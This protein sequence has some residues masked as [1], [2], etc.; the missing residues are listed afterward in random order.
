MWHALNE[1]EIFEKLKSSENGLD[2]KEAAGRL[3]EYGLNEL[4]E[5]H[6]ISPIKIFLSQFVSILVYI[7]IIAA[8]IS[9]LLK[10]WIDFWVI[11]AIVLLNAF[12]GFIQQYKA[13]RAVRELKQMI[14]PRVKVIR[15][16]RLRTM[17]SLHIVPGDIIALD[18]GDKIPADAR[19]LVAN[20]LQ[21][22]EAVLTGE[23]MPV[24]KEA[25]T[26]KIG[27]ELVDRNNMLYMGTSIVRG[28]ARAIVVESGMSTE[29]G[30]IAESV[31]TIEHEKTPL[32]KRFDIFAK[33][34]GFFIIAV[35]IFIVLFGIF[36]GFDKLQIFLTSIAL[37][38]SA[39]PEGLPAVLTLGLALA[40]R[41]LLKVNALVKKLPASETLGSASVLCVDKTGTITSEE[42]TVSY[43]YSN[44]K[45]LA[46]N[47][48]V[49]KGNAARDV[50]KIGVLCN[51]SRVEK[52]RGKNVF[53]G[54]PTEK[55]LLAIAERAGISKRAQTIQEPK[56][57]EFPFSSERKMMSIVR[58]NKTGFIS[59]VKGSPEAVLSRSAY[60]LINGEIRILTSKRRMQLHKEYEKFASKALRVLAFAFKPIKREITL[61]NAESKLIFA[62]FQAMIDPPRPEI[63]ESIKKCNEFGIRVMMITG[64]SA[65]TARV[66]A[67][68]IGLK[69]MLITS[70]ELDKLS[71]KKL[72]K[73]IS[74]VSIFARIS[75]E[76]K[77]RIVESLKRNGEIVAVTGDGVN[78]V[79]ALKKADVA[80]AMG[81]RGTDVARDVSDIVLLDDNF[82]SIVSAVEEGRKTYSNIRKFTKFLLSCN[83]SEIGLVI[84]S[85]FAKLPLPLL[86]L[87]ILWINLITDSAPALALSAEPKNSEKIRDNN[88]KSILKGM[89]GFIL[90]GGLLAFLSGIS[91]FFLGLWADEPIEKIRTSVLTT[92]ILFQLLFAFTCRSSKSLIK[93]GP[94]T[95]RWL[96]AAFAGAFALQILLIY[97]P[98][99]FAFEVVPLGFNDWIPIIFASISGLLVFEIMKLI[100]FSRLIFN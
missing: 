92:S 21:A 88:D 46:A 13:E 68:Q 57:K 49:K 98:L 7:L 14:V 4:K 40:T 56:V 39:I 28:N 9:A 63:R 3:R 23:S 2:E 12:F 32:Q 81:I 100:K 73:I 51:N 33:Q 5:F 26:L 75:P 64:D 50:L 82:K 25:G 97:S 36:S 15:E 45:I 11:S 22:N 83:F 85:I 10:H 95:N 31:Q 6:K 53:I 47:D 8:L 65:L 44:N 67:E 93:I 69:G 16:G 37:V 35:A 59:Y 99:G 30:E 89:F 96:L 48:A 17:L 80:I 70:D 91:V 1:K 24:D 72:D 42:M 38:V 58:K 27:A 76:H 19:I 52:H 20:N 90:I 62:G 41:R 79:L 78:D 61:E 18:E 66:I 34:I 94:F 87:Q 43:I 74:E 71:D 86:P 77:L 29:F 60:E 84:L 54:D 55:A